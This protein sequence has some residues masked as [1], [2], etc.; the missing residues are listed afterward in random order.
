M[1]CVE[2]A[3]VM[4]IIGKADGATLDRIDHVIATLARL[5]YKRA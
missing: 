5:I 2:V 1:A 4:R 3:Q